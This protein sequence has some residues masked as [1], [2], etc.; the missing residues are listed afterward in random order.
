MQPPFSR[1]RG[2]RGE[3]YHW[4]SIGL[5]QSSTFRMNISMGCELGVP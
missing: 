4:A 3:L 5:R 1:V 2:E